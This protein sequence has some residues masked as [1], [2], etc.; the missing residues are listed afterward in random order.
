VSHG[1]CGLVTNP[2]TKTQPSPRETLLTLA[3][4]IQKSCPPTSA[5]HFLLRNPAPQPPPTMATQAQPPLES[6]VI[7]PLEITIP[8]D[9][10]PPPRSK[11]SDGIKRRIR[12][13]LHELSPTG[14]AEALDRLA[15]HLRESEPS[16][17]LL[18]PHSLPPHSSKTSSPSTR[19]RSCGRNETPQFRCVKCLSL[20][21]HLTPSPPRWGF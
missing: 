1:V 10:L 20:F 4:D 7:S 2:P 16:S 19:A 12:T 9:P 8:E 5:S 3:Q 14:D 13:L 17:T 18:P 21:T 11:K 6:L 15:S